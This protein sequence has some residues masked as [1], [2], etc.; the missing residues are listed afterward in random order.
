MSNNISLPIIVEVDEDGCFIVNCP[1]IRG[2]RSYGNTIDEAM[3]NVKEAIES[4]LDEQ[5]NLLDNVNK[6]VGVREISIENK[7]GFQY[8]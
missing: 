5:S 6:Y 7:S 3:A 8:A 2:C 1:S 4:C